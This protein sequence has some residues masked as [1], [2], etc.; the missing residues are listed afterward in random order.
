MTKAHMQR[1]GWNKRLLAST[2]G[3][4]LA[5]LRMENRTVNELAAT[6]GLTGN[7]IRAHLLGLERDG[8]VQQHGI[9][10][11]TR[12]PHVA[13][14]LSDEAEQIFPKAYGLLLNHLVK[15][16]SKRLRPF[17]LRGTMRDVGAALARD[18][19]HGLKGRSRRDRV[20]IALDL[21]HDLGGSAKFDERGGKQFIL[22]RN[23]CP[24]AAITASHPEGCLIVESMLSKIIGGHVRKCCDYGEIP[25]CCF[26]LGRK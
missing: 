26:E 1:S 6:L 8:L 16:L 17:A 4:I 21:L 23:G 25:R 12:K 19:L 22:G 18:Y 13:Y 24:L 7:A 14:G 11:G 15:V 10:R 2:R 3:Q 20:K 5:L 9:R